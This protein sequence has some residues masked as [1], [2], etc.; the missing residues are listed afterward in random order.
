LLHAKTWAL[1]QNSFRIIITGKILIPLLLLIAYVSVLI[2][3]MYKLSIWDTMLLKDTIFWFLGVALASFF[4]ST[5]AKNATYFKQ[6]I[7]NAIKWTIGI[8]FLVNLY[9]FGLIAELFIVPMMTMLL[10][11]KTVAQMDKNN[12]KVSTVLGDVLGW[13]G[14]FLF[15][16]ILY[17]TFTHAEMLVTVNNLKEFLL[18]PSLTFL[19]LPF[20]YLVVLYIH[21]DEIFFRINLHTNDI[22]HRN[23]LKRKILWRINFSLTRLQY[24][25]PKIY[26][27]GHCNEK[28][29]KR[30]FNKYKFFPK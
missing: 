10:V 16:I 11:I 4:Q 17:K 12:E 18:P 9:S 24:I 14:F 29:L 5:K 27:L 6:I 15:G 30:Y 7:F 26:R 1:L 19:F 3:C 21:Y 2:Y 23:K 25:G 13:T 22:M 20:L 28:A 8:E